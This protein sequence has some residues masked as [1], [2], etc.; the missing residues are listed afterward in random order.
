MF[1]AIGF[2]AGPQYPPCELFPSTIGL[3]SNVSRS[4]PVIELIVLIALSASAPAR[5]AARAG[6]RISQIFGVSFT[7]TGV[8]ARS[9]THSVIRSRIL[10]HLPHRRPH[11]ALAHPMRTPEVQLQPIRPRPLRPRH[12]LVPRLALR[13]PPSA[14]RSPHA[15]DTSASPPQ[16][17]AGSSRSAGPR[18]TQYC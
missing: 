3:G 12:H 9:F 5:F 6:I 14:T 4:I 16:S 15:S 2:T 11:P 7:I 18:S 13:S 8:R 10:R 1:S 17:P